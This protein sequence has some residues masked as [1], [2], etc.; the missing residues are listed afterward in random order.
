MTKTLARV[1]VTLDFYRNNLRVKCLCLFS[2]HEESIYTTN[3]SAYCV[4]SIAVLGQDSSVAL[5]S[6]H[7][8]IWEWDSWC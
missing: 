7:D 4:V 2:S 6:H 1:V 5:H 3:R 8:C